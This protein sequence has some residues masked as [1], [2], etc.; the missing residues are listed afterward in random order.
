MNSILKKSALLSICHLYAQICNLGEKKN[1]LIS[2]FSLFVAP[3]LLHRLDKRTTN[4]L[5]IF[6]F[7]SFICGVALSVWSVETGER[8]SCRAFCCYSSCTKDIRDPLGG[9]STWRGF[10]MFHYIVTG[11]QRCCATNTYKHEIQVNYEKYVYFHDSASHA[12]IN[13]HVQQW[14]HTSLGVCIQRCHQSIAQE[15]ELINRLASCWTGNEILK[16]TV[17]LS[18]RVNLTL[19]TRASNQHIVTINSLKFCVLSFC[20]KFGSGHAE[21]A[22]A[23]FWWSTTTSWN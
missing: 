15:R 13:T 18:P 4:A 1:S 10:K 22:S 14:T 17:F 2:I 19:C 3:I 12:A 9:F 20:C 8:I 5:K 6:F 7:C 11:R 21:A 16:W 23:Q